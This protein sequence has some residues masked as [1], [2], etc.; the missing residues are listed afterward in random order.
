[1]TILLVI[2][3]FILLGRRATISKSPL[4]NGSYLAIERTNIINSFFIV[5]VI[6]RHAY[7]P[8]W[9]SC[10]NPLDLLY[11]KYFDQP[12]GQS[13]VSTFFFFSGYGIM[14]SI[15]K[16]GDF[17]IRKLISHRFLTLYIN[18][19]ICSTISGISYSF[20]DCSLTEGLRFIWLTITGQGIYW[21]IIM[22]LVI[23]LSTF[24]T[25]RLFG[26]KNPTKSI[27][28]LSGILY[29]ICLLLSRYKPSWW[30]DTELCFCF[31]MLFSLFRPFIESKLKKVPLP[32]H[33]IGAICLLTGWLLIL[34][35]YHV[36]EALIL[37]GHKKLIT[38]G[39]RIVLLP[40]SCTIFV[41]GIAWL[42][43]KLTFKAPP[44]FFIWLGGSAVFYLYTLH[45]IP[46]RILRAIGWGIHNP[47]ISILL[48][49][50][51]S[52]ILAYI[53]S[54]LIPL[55]QNRLLF[56]LRKFCQKANS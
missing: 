33:W 23:Y 43:S 30:V 39:L 22:T 36:Q 20:I 46:I 12:A 45:L 8:H 1:M 15:A 54:N 48:T 32:I 47:E 28:F 31:G 42:T 16:K 37:A 35:T 5:F 38:D 50:V 53:G 34:L 7:L 14:L 40:V 3:L 49:F 19:A 44:V 10:L 52:L 11:Y 26:T 9:D 13:I 25:F 27:I 17:Y 18:M 41:L 2:I 21:F 4:Q 56:I 29:I 24:F 55:I 6:L 51:A